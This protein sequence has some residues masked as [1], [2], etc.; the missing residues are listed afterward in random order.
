MVVDDE[1]IFSE[2][3]HLFCGLTSFYLRIFFTVDVSLQSFTKKML[4]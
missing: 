2:I 1:A 3:L 4:V